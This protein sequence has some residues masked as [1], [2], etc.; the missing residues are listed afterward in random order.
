MDSLRDRDVGQRGDASPPT[1][2]EQPVAK[3]RGGGKEH[4]GSENVSYL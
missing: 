2:T 1:V 4:K 3:W